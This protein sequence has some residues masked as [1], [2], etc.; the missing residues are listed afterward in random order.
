VTKVPGF[1]RCYCSHYPRL[2][3]VACRPAASSRNGT[4]STRSRH[5]CTRG[6]PRVRWRSDDPE[7]G[8]CNDSSAHHSSDGIPLE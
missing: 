1:C 3:S 5:C 8:P 6:T 2:C 7:L 4:M